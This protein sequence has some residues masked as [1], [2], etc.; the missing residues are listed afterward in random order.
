MLRVHFSDSVQTDHSA[1]ALYAFEELLRRCG[2]SVRCETSPQN[3]DIVYGNDEVALTSSVSI[4]HI[5]ADLDLYNPSNCAPIFNATNLETT[6]EQVSKGVIDPIGW[7]FRFLT[8]ADEEGSVSARPDGNKNHAS[9]PPWRQRISHLPVVEYLSVSLRDSLRA[10]GVECSDYKGLGR[11]AILLTHDTDATNLSHPLEVIYNLLKG[12]VR[13]KH[14]DLARA[15]HGFQQRGADYAENPLFGFQRWCQEFPEYKH[16][17]YLSFRGATKPTLNDVRSSASDRRFPWK[18][19]RSLSDTGFVEY[20]LHPGINTRKHQKHYTNI[21]HLC[22]EKLQMP[23]NG[24][25]HHYWALDW[26]N[27][28]S[29]YR[30]MVS[31]GFRYDCSMAYPDRFGLRSGTCLP[32]R[33]FDSRYGRPLNLYLLPT[34]VMDSW[35]VNNNSEELAAITKMLAEIR[36]FN[37]LVNLDWHTEATCNTYPYANYVDNLHRL[38]AENG[39]T[40][41]HSILP[42]ELVKSWHQKIDPLANMYPHLRIR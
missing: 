28:A 17:F 1:K 34:C 41:G 26:S 8:L 9:L 20:G 38:L 10:Q 36:A 24:L 42:G 3:A 21:K 16:C 4:G 37:G 22:E 18:L 14:S 5:R 32:Y 15:V 40:P 6:R 19:I 31:A 12:V 30:K 33:P 29:S 2:E 13:R 11:Y 39:L 7:A 23:I 25:R 27:P 35:V